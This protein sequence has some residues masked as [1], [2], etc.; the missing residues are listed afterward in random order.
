MA[1]L[2]LSRKCK[3]FLCQ[4]KWK[5]FHSYRERNMNDLP[6]TFCYARNRT[7]I[8]RFFVRGK[9]EKDRT[10]ESFRNAPLSIGNAVKHEVA[11]S[12]RS[13]CTSHPSIHPSFL[14]TLHKASTTRVEQPNKTTIGAYKRNVFL[15]LHELFNFFHLR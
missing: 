6:D 14:L 5:A 3:F 7:L 11:F 15:F 9:E 12:T 8:K 1:K 13:P 10:T 4:A 2:V